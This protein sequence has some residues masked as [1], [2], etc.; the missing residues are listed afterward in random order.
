MER[1]G[2]ALLLSAVDAGVSLGQ[3]ELAEAAPPT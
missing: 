2:A 3:A 1:F